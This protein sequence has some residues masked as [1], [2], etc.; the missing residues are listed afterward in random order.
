MPQRIPWQSSGQNSALS[1]PRACVP[2][3]VG[4]LI[5]QG[6]C[7]CFEGFLVDLWTF[8]GANI[9]WGSQGWQVDVLRSRYWFTLLSFLP[10]FRLLL[11]PKTLIQI[12]ANLKCSNMHR[13]RHMGNCQLLIWLQLSPGEFKLP[14]SAFSRGEVLSSPSW[15]Y[16]YQF[17]RSAQEFSVFLRCGE[18]LCH[19]QGRP[20]PKQHKCG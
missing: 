11:H 10:I 19:S 15:N 7:C 5:S 1:L 17:S 6:F 8:L 14:E 4:E 13:L 16:L 9:K 2:S 12:L 18:N 20:S 3:L